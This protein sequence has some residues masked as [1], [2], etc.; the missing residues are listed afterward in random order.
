MRIKCLAH[1]YNHRC[2][3]QLLLNKYNALDPKSYAS[4]T[5]LLPHSHDTIQV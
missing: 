3:L 2:D 4:I 1:N 5:I